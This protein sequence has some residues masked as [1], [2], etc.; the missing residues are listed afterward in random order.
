MSAVERVM[1]KIVLQ[2]K[3]DFYTKTDREWFN[4]KKNTALYSW[5]K[6]RNLSESSI[7]EPR[8]LALPNCKALRCIKNVLDYVDKHPTKW[9]PCYGWSVMPGF[10]RCDCYG[11]EAHVVLQR[12]DGVLVDI[13]PD[14]EGN[15]TKLFCPDPT[16]EG[17]FIGIL[18]GVIPHSLMGHDV[19]KCKQC[20]GNALASFLLDK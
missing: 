13:T 2:N 1:S 11:L 19:G 8:I 12:N 16:V 6:D 7:V 17:I 3:M 20:R 18:H 15:R 5:L 9:Y 4:I 10:H 14:V